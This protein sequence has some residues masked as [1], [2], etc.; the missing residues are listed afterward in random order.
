MP[1]VSVSG[2]AK[3]RGGATILLSALLFGVAGAFAAVGIDT[4]KMFA[5]RRAVQGAT[6]LAALAAATDVTNA[7]GIA[8]STLQRNLRSPILNVGVITGVYRADVSVPPDQRFV[9]APAAQANAVRVTTD[10][11]S[12]LFFA[13]SFLGQDSARIRTQAT[14]A[15]SAFGGFAIGSRL[16]SLNGGL[17]NSLLSSMTGS[18]ISLDVA[19]YRALVDARIELFDFARAL[20]TRAG[21]T[22]L[23]YQDVLNANVRIADVAGALADLASANGRTVA[24]RSLVRLA[25]SAASSRDT[26]AAGGLL[27]LGPFSGLS[28]THNPGPALAV[29]AFDVFNAAVSLAN[30]RR[31]V[32][33][34]LGGTVPGI[35]SLTLRVGVGERPLGTS[36]VMVGTTGT[37]VHT[38]QIRLLLVARINAADPLLTVTVP[39]YVEVARGTASLAGVSCPWNGGPPRMDL[40]V[41]PG[42]IDARIGAVSV[43]DFANDRSR[44]P[45]QAAT[46]V[47]SPLLKILGRAQFGMSNVAPQT[48]A[49]TQADIDNAIIRTVTT[50]DFSQSLVGGL[51]STLQLDVQLLGLNLA[52]TTAVNQLLRD[53]IQPVT[54]TID[55]ILRSALSSL[56]VAVGQADVWGLALRCDGAVLV[57]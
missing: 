27:N 12:E 50:R 23:T 4:G 28:L 46:L 24:A 43:V 5:D 56:G 42:V 14:A 31:Q 17:L 34:D 10:A 44:P 19:D 33:L 49:F 38:A 40:T 37:T 21:I 26:F 35:A 48:V 3:D 30:G 13:R 55:G 2:F 22:A 25:Q 41:R 45:L 6:D 52:G 39:V 47:S 18:S 1:R 57:N 53:T 51:A 7:D 9:P 29:S 32:E 8:V 15:S 20:K 54:P 16:A 11:S 36:W